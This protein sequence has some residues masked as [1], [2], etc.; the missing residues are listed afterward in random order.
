[1]DLLEQTSEE[2]K[3][4]F[5]EDMKRTSEDYYEKHFEKDYDKPHTFYN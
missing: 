5:L 4:E 1:M 2:L 3:A